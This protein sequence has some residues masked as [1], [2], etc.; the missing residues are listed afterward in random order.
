MQSGRA[1]IQFFLCQ[2]SCHMGKVDYNETH[3]SGLTIVAT[4]DA[5]AGAGATIAAVTCIASSANS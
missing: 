3:G 4:A 2:N 5:I 1:K